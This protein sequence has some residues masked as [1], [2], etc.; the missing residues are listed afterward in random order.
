MGRKSTKMVK[1]RVQG[2]NGYVVIGED[3]IVG[4]GTCKALVRAIQI[5][6]GIGTPN[7]TFGPAT[8][9]AF[10]AMGITE[11]TSNQ[12]LIRILQ[13][14]FYCKGIDCGG[15][16]GVHGYKLSQAILTFKKQTGIGGNNPYIDAKHMK[17]LLNTDPFIGDRNGKVYIRVAQQYLNSN[18][19]DF[20]WEKIGLIP[21]NGITDRNMTKA[22]AYA[23]QYEEGERGSGLDGV[24]GTNT[25]NKAPVL[26]I[27]SLKGNFIKLLQ[28]A[29]ACTA[30]EDV[31]LDGVFDQEV[32]HAVSNHQR[33]MCLNQD[34]TVTLGVVCRKTWA[35][36]MISK[37]DVT[38]FCDACD[39]SQ[40]LSLAKARALKAHGYNYVGRYLTGTVGGSR[41]KSLSVDEI[42]N[43]TEAGLN[44]FAIYQDGGASATYFNY[45]KGYSDAK[46]AIIAAEKLHIPLGEIIYFAVDYD[47]TAD[48]TKDIIV[49]HFRGINDYFN[50]VN[51][52]YRIGI[53]G[54]RNICNTVA[55]ENLSCSS[56]VSDMSTGYS[57]NMGYRLPD[58]WAFDQFY[59][60]T[61]TNYDNYDGDFALDKNV[62]SG[63]YTGFNGNMLCGKEKYRD[64]TLHKMVLQP[65]GYYECS[66]CGYRVKH[67]LLQDSQILSVRELLEVKT[68]YIF[69]FNYCYLESQNVTY[70]NMDSPKMLLDAIQRIRATHINAYEFS[71][72]N[73][74]CVVDQILYPH[75][76]D[77]MYFEY[78]FA[79][80]EVNS[81]NLIIYDGT[82]AS[83]MNAVL[84][85][86]S[87][88]YA[89]YQSAQEIQEIID[90]QSGLEEMVLMKIVEFFASKATAAMG[91]DKVLEYLVSLLELGIEIDTEN[92]YD[93]EVGDY[94][95]EYPIYQGSILT[96]KNSFIVYDADYKVKVIVFNDMSS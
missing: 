64:V 34:T 24:V 59:E 2:K 12:N 11:S 82:L 28:I 90:N 65:D 14:G 80:G 77:K 52:K 33:F 72:G 8:I 96:C 10:N 3:G 7:G 93:I 36:F 26:S 51:S 95:V 32:E 79:Y 70:S 55:S 18:Y 47:F 39:C 94:I 91:G 84:C 66:V 88:N 20:F 61:F 22:L 89:L 54:S 87:P 81:A 48:Q 19:S 63:R 23:L 27:G 21:C 71:D 30:L 73:G 45:T 5:E 17:A 43:I 46:K 40:K 9:S 53:Y 75:N 6:L 16:D 92:G 56:F 78:P 60:Y 44:I 50:K 4:S 67:P 58:D 86:F 74:V 41:D 62:A 69:F 83:I 42:T 29:I 37:G 31:G 13:G 76:P 85:I 68:G 15:F 25:L 57:G 49:P 35:S 38:R 1:Q